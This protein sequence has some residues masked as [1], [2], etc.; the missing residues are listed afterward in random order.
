MS[1]HRATCP[2]TLGDGPLVCTRADTHEPHHGCTY[3]S[4][5]GVPDAPKEE[6]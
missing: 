5:S 3:E 6:L 1:K 2:A 4:T